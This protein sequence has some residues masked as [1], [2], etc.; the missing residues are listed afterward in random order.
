MTEVNCQICG[1]VLRIDFYECPDCGFKNP[2]LQLVRRH[3]YRISFSPEVTVTMKR[4][5]L[6]RGKS[7]DAFVN[8]AVEWY[9]SKIATR[10][11]DG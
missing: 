3:I 6:D 8:E 9:I 5:A 7:V 2:Q 11:A 4:M 1:K 10:E